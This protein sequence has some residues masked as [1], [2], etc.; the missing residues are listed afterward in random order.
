MLESDEAMEKKAD[1]STEIMPN[2]LGGFRNDIFGLF[3]NVFFLTKTLTKEGGKDVYKYYAITNKRDNRNG[4]N[5]FGLNSI[6]ENP[7][8]Q[9][10][11][12]AIEEAMKT[13]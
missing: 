6:I 3:S 11:K 2:I 4:K 1:K 8:H 7:S 5:R 12:N 9:V 10:I 13:K